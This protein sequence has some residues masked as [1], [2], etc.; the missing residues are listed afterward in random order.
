M[1][2]LLFSPHRSSQKASVQVRA[3]TYFALQ[4]FVFVLSAL[5]PTPGGM[6]GVEAAFFFI[7]QAFIPRD[8][9]AMITTGWRLLSFYLPVVLGAFTLIAL[10]LPA[11]YDAVL[12]KT[13][14]TRSPSS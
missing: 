2:L 12:P 8:M 6:V 11:M 5:L 14:G 10:P 7:F 1:G 3:L 13:E 9:I 4:W